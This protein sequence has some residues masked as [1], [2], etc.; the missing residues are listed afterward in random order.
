MHAKLPRELR[1]M[2][3][4][5][6]W[7]ELEPWRIRWIWSAAPGSSSSSYR[8]DEEAYSPKSVSGFEE[9]RRDVR[10]YEP[11]KTFFNTA[12]FNKEFLLELAGDWYYKF[13]LFVPDRE[14]L[15]SFLV[16][17]GVMSVV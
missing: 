1:D 7:A 5:L 9:Q 4:S 11:D 13:G 14:H 8:N 17:G 3:Y 6:F 12:Y 2:V 15:E 16:H 10:V